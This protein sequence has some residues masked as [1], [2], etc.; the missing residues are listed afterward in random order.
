MA[1]TTVFNDIS[2]NA[3]VEAENETEIN[4][5]A[6]FTYVRNRNQLSVVLS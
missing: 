1:R 2:I 4:K 3:T 5:F 6:D